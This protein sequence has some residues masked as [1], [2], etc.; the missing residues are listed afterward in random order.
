MKAPG[1]GNVL[2][3]GKPSG[4][5]FLP[6]KK[7]LHKFCPH[8]V[9]SSRAFVPLRCRQFGSRCPCRGYTPLPARG[10]LRHT[11]V[12]YAIRGGAPLTVRPVDLSRPPD[13][14]AA[15]AS[16]AAPP[17]PRRC[18]PRPLRCQ[19]GCQ[20]YPASY[21]PPTT[22]APRRLGAMS[23]DVVGAAPARAPAE[24]VRATAPAIARRPAASSSGVGV[25]ATAPRRNAPPGCRSLARLPTPPDPPSK[26]GRQRKPAAFA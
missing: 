2:H 24:G 9:P 3:D 18:L 22:S 21:L 12:R 8:K 4:R 1:G 11:G 20:T 14:A 17:L 13:V 15:Y 7:P 25:L 19:G 26:G 10:W 16:C 6:R 5:A 23:V